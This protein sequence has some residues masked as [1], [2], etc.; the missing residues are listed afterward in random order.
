MSKYFKVGDKVTMTQNALENYG[1]KYNGVI[2]T[3][4]VVSKNENDHPGYDM[5]V[6]PMR[7]YDLSLPDGSDFPCSLYDWELNTA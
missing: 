2:F 6:F 5:G 3:I 4:T 7:L 1:Y